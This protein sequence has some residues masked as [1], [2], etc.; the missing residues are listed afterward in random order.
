M[1]NLS[2]NSLIHFGICLQHFQVFLVHSFKE[3]MD[4]LQ[5]NMKRMDKKCSNSISYTL[6]NNHHSVTV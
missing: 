6:V 5:D 3:Q 2:V 1:N 4:M